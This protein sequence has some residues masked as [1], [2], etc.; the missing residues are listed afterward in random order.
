MLAGIQSFQILLIEVKEMKVLLIII[1][2][3][4]SLF[5]DK[6]YVCKNLDNLIVEGFK[7]NLIGM[8]DLQ[9]RVNVSERDLIMSKNMLESNKLALG[10]VLNR[11]CGA[12]GTSLVLTNGNSNVNFDFASFSTPYYNYISK[13]ICNNEVIRLKKLAL[14]ISR[15]EFSEITYYRNSGLHDKYIPAADTIYYLELVVKNGNLGYKL[16]DPSNVVFKSPEQIA[17]RQICLNN[18]SKDKYFGHNNR[19]YLEFMLYMTLSRFDKVDKIVDKVD[20]SILS[21]YCADFKEDI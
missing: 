9:C 13:L 5:A 20:L 3:S 14:L 15:P 7:T 6:T 2:L 19:S 17:L 1:T 18:I 10:K 16:E 8:R 12:L 11:E 21:D 4:L